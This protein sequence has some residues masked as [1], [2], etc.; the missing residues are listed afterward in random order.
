MPPILVGGRGR[1]IRF[2]EQR[3]GRDI[4]PDS[5]GVF[6]IYRDDKVN[7]KQSVVLS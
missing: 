3:G 4:Y 7:V 5:N 6:E 2:G 1:M